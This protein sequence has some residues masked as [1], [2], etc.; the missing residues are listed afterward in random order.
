MFFYR[1][2]RL[3]STR[4]IQAVGNILKLAFYLDLWLRP[5]KRYHIPPISR[6]LL[7]GR[8]PRAI[9]SIVWLTNYTDQVTLAL[10][11]NYLF[12]RCMAP[13]HEFRF[14]GDAECDA[15]MKTQPAEIAE[16]YG[17][18]QIGAA[19][20]DLWRIAI[21]HRHGGIYMDMDAALSWP[22][23]FLLRPDQTELFAREN[24]GRLTNYFLAARPAHPV[25]MDIAAKIVANISANAIVSVYDMTGPTVVDEVAGKAAVRTEPSR[26]LCRQGQFTRKSM[27]YPDKLKGYWAEEETIRPIV[28]PS[29]ETAPLHSPTD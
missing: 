19:R 29:A 17:K 3:A 12:N 22:P 24:G 11:F 21:L 18:L 16:A 8:R 13:A 28:M 9:P 1:G 10:Y 4:L 27:Q 26:F 7:K 15:F 23:G 14:H 6:P 2:A 20:A 25:L 5:N